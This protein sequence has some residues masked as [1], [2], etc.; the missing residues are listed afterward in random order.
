MRLYNAAMGDGWSADELRR[1]GLGE[2][3]EKLRTRRR[4]AAK[5]P[6]DGEHCRRIG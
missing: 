2:P 6:R 1:L 4:A 5:K 3:E